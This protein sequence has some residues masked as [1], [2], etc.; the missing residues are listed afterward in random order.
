MNT[1]ERG[2]GRSTRLLQTALKHAIEG[3]EPRLVVFIV[4]M[5]KEDDYNFR[6]VHELAKDQIKQYS[7]ANRMIMFKSGGRIRFMNWDDDNLMQVAPGRWR[8]AG[9][10]ADT[11]VIWDHHAEDRWAERE[12]V[13]NRPVGGRPEKRR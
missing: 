8:V 5:N 6:I 10:R 11:P 1:G 4:G 9:Y 3:P 13:R 12:V 7:M 2:T